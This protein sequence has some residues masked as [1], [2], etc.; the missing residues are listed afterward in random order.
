M[1]FRDILEEVGLEARLVDERDGVVVSVGVPIPGSRCSSTN[2]SGI[3]GMEPRM[4]AS[5]IPSEQYL[6]LRDVV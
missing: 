6:I 4:Y 5:I 3:D 2:S 1:P